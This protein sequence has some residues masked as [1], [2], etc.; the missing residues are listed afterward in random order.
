M[1]R[2][3]RLVVAL[4]R[5]LFVDPV[6]AAHRVVHGIS[7][8][9]DLSQGTGSRQSGV[10]EPRVHPLDLGHALLESAP[11]FPELAQLLRDTS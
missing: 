7:V 10:L 3:G 11:L 8:A 6:C 1:T 4:G 9:R 5:D 2:S